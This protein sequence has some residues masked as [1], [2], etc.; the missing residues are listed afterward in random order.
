MILFFILG[1]PRRLKSAYL[2]CLSANLSVH[3]LTMLPPFTTW[4]L[5]TGLVLWDLFAVLAPCGPLKWIVDMIHASEQE[6]EN[7]NLGS[8]QARRSP[9]IRLPEVMLYSTVAMMSKKN[10]FND[11]NSSK[12]YFGDDTI[13]PS[14]AKRRTKIAQMRPQLGLGDFIFY[15]LLVGKTATTTTSYV[16]ILFVSLSILV[17]LLSTLSLLIAYRRALPALPISLSLA[18]LVL[19][20]AYHCA[21]P[22]LTR[23]NVNLIFL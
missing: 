21:E 15:S 14:R 17:G 12:D 7:G 8:R 16:T 10:D 22:W 1:G 20:I 6:H 18:L 13:T 9:P 3:I 2:I 11:Q 23:L 5:L 4:A 19:P